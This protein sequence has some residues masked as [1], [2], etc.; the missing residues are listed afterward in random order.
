MNDE[1]KYN[2]IKKPT[3][4]KPADSTATRSSGHVPLYVRLRFPNCSVIDPDR[5][6][7]SEIETPNKP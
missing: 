2:R 4:T 7:A 6:K 5:K 1:P 3:R